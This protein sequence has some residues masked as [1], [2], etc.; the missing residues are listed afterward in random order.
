MVQSNER[1]FISSVGQ[2]RHK[3]PAYQGEDDDENLPLRRVVIDDEEEEGSQAVSDPQE[4]LHA[5]GLPYED[6]NYG[7]LSRSTNSSRGNEENS[8]TFP[9]IAGLASYFGEDEVEDQT[10]LQQRNAP[11]TE[12]SPISYR[13]P[14]RETYYRQSEQ[15]A[16]GYSYGS[17]SQTTYRITQS[18][19]TNLVTI[20]GRTYVR[21]TTS[22]ASQ[23]YR[24]AARG[25]FLKYT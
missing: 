25:L 2:E 6:H 13:G 5:S 4:R 10:T 16:S 8:E 1:N 21:Q 7:D 24:S 23:G 20:G 19:G 22:N 12:P 15:N 17:Q 11:V 3:Q 9:V 14:I 18:P